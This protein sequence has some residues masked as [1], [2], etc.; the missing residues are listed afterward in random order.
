MR[1]RNIRS[2]ARSTSVTRSITPFLST[3]WCRP[4]CAICM[5]PART[6]ASTAV[7]RNRGLDIERRTSKPRTTNERD[8]SLNGTVGGGIG[9]GLH[10]L[11]HADFH[12]AP[13][14]AVQLHI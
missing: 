7:V 11:D 13:R 5:S 3:W 6:T 1:A 4:N 12:A 9:G 2:T 10:A 8:L 14:H